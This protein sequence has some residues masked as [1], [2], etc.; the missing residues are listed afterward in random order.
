MAT[1]SLPDR[2]HVEVKA[3]GR[4]LGGLLVLTRIIMREKNDFFGIFGPTND[5][6]FLTIEKDELLREAATAREFY[7]DEFADP[8][9][10]F[11]G[12]V[13]VRVLDESGIERAL[14]AHA[15]L[16]EFPYRE[17]HVARLQAA[18]IALDAI[19]R[20]LMEVFVTAEGG[21]SEVKAEVPL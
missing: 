18:Q 17:G 10:A 1:P 5:L 2:I 4:P 3:R 13:E 20:V 8:L 15:E 16:R 7:P 19:G 14:E 6:G 11:G 21:T 12:L 9:A